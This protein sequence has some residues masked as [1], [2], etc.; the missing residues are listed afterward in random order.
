MANAPQYGTTDTFASQPAW[1]QEATRG[2]GSQ[3]VAVAGQ[4]Y[5]PYSAPNNAATYGVDT[6]RIA[7][8]NPTQQ[9]AQQTVLANQGSYQPYTDYASQTLPQAQ[10]A[11][12]NPYTQSVVDRIAQLGQRNLTESIL[13]QIN[14]TFVGAGQFGSDR[15]ASFMNRAMRDANESILG[16]QADA[17]NKGYTQS[18]DAALKDMQ[19]YA[20]LGQQ[21]QNQGYQDVGMMDTIGQVQQNL[22]QKNMDMSYQDFVNQRDHQK[23][24]LSWAGSVLTGLPKVSETSSIVASP[25]NNSITMS[26]LAAYA[27]GFAGSMSR[28]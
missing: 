13:P 28:K 3:A 25:Q 4:P 1:L 22:A 11:Y 16:Q 19:R 14:S 12:M 20:Q 26:P 6:G 2:V 7:G 8:F 5:Q 15:N 17:L 10:G 21:V 23:N 24:Q 27:Q 9:Y 18:Q